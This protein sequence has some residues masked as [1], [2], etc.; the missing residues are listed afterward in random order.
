MIAKNANWW[1]IYM[2]PLTETKARAGTPRFNVIL[3]PIR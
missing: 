1:G 3:A 2:A